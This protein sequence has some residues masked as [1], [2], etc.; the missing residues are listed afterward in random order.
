MANRPQQTPLVQ[1]LPA[2]VPFVG[3]ETQER[4]RGRVFRARI[5]ANESSFGPSPAVTARDGAG[6][7]RHVEILRPGKPRPQGGACRASRHSAGNVVVGE[8]ID[9]LLG[10]VARMYLEPGRRGGHLARR[11]SDLQLPYRRV[12]RPAGDGAL[13]G[14]REDLDALAR[15][16]TPRE[17]ATGLLSNPD[18]PMGT[19]WEAADI[20]RFIEALPETTMLV[21]D[22]AYGETGPASAHPAARPR[23]AE[24]HQDAHLLKSYGLAG[25]RCGYA[26]GETETIRAF[27][28]VRNHYGVSKMAQVAAQAALADQDYLRSVVARVAAGRERIA[29]DSPRQR[30]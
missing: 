5:G 1:S 9:G 6:R 12:R 4:A 21:L 8:G 22:E 27:D 14:D 16:R 7:R 28:K 29:G 17:R 23:P 18:N 11:L 15:G 13:C 24:R 25:L 20:T 2:T 10:L 19:W 3:P 30:T 26:V